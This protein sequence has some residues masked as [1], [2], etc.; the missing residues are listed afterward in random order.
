MTGNAASKGPKTA[1]G[2]PAAVSIIIANM[3]GTGVFTSL[4]FQLEDLS[5]GFPILALWALG[6]VAAF[7]G[8]MCY[9]EIGS[10]LPR[11]G[12]E[13]SL[14]REIYHPAAGFVSGFVSASVAFAA[15]TALAAMTFSAYGLSVLAPEAPPGAG[16]AAAIALVALLSVAHAA[17]RRLSGAVQ[18]AF[19]AFKVAAILLFCAGAAFLLEAPEPVSFLPVAGDGAVIASGAFAV[20]LIYVSYA[21]AGWNAA[22]Y[23]TGEIENPSRNLPRVFAAGSLVVAL[24]YVALN[25]AF[26]AA[27]PAEDLVGKVEIGF[28]AAKSIFGPE[29]GALVGL[30]MASLLVSTVSAMTIAGPRVLQ[31]IG[32]DFSVF[33]PLAAVNRDGIPA[34]AIYAQGAVAII[35]IA[36]SGFQSVLVFAGFLTALNSFFTVL[37]LFVLRWRRPDLRRPFR[38]PLFPI[39]PL[40]YLA[41]TLWTLVYAALSRPVE[42]AYAA[43]LILIGLAVWALSAR[44]GR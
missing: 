36:T 9:A 15:P 38:T 5:P 22:A 17:R 34:R 35:L 40:V 23:I 29:A 2:F 18:T 26:M 28:I 16:K 14:L 24:L 30:V 21:Y 37:G 41:L 44:A 4:G 19:T 11:S 12:G 3:I 25:A 6:G 20:S 39:T 33:R 42:I 27:A 31:A 13:Y 7:A 1:Y 32:E 8:A 10:A 43:G